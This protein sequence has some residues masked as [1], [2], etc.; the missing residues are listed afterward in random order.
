MGYTPSEPQ[1]IVG[2]SLVKEYNLLPTNQLTNCSICH[3]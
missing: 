2:A 3:R 1:A